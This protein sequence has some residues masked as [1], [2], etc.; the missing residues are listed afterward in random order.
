MSFVIFVIFVFDWTIKNSEPI[1]YVKS[2]VS[3][4]LQVGNV[5]W[6]LAKVSY[7]VLINLKVSVVELNILEAVTVNSL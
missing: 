3:I 1:S 5:N 2:S 7:V 6:G 4:I